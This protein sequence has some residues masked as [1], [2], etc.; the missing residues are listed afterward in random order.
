ML[1]QRERLFC[2]LWFTYSRDLQIDNSAGAAG[3][4]WA[5]LKEITNL[6]FWRQID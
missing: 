1:N 5:I 6:R 3:K 4:I 2:Y